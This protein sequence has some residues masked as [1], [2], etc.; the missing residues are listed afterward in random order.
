MPIRRSPNGRRHTPPRTPQPAQ[1]TPEQLRGINRNDCSGSIGTAARDEPV[2]AVRT[3]ALDLPL[4]DDVLA[5]L[6]AL[7]YPAQSLATD[8]PL[9]RSLALRSRILGQTGDYTA[10]RAHIAERASAFA[11]HWPRESLDFQT[12]GGV[13]GA[14]SAFSWL[15][16]TVFSFAQAMP[17]PLSGKLAFI[18]GATRDIAKCWPGTIRACIGVFSDS[19]SFLDVEAASIVW[20]ALLELRAYTK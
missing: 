5:D 18:V 16:D 2:R 10:M 7:Q 12:L 19:A 13:A 17:S 9:Q 11:K 8:F 15:Y 1:D 20:P 3:C 6:N 4:R 14:A